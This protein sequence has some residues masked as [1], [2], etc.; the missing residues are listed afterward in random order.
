[1]ADG[2]P[3]DEI[4]CYDKDIS[5]IYIKG[6]NNY[7]ISNRYALKDTRDYQYRGWIITRDVYGLLK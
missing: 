2:T 4:D 1:V 6:I 3:I 7:Q 5:V